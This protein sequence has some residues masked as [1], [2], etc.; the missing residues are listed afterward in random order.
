M[1]GISALSGDLAVIGSDITRVFVL[2]VPL[3][4]MMSPEMRESAKNINEGL[5]KASHRVGFNLTHWDRGLLDEDGTVMPRWLISRS[6]V[7]LNEGGYLRFALFLRSLI[8][9]E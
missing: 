9:S 4:P 5:K 8:T 3:L 2:E 7:H 1:G 6:D